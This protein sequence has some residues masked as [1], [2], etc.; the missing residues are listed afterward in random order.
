MG[1]PFISLNAEFLAVTTT[2]NLRMNFI[3][4]AAHDNA[5]SECEQ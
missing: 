5:L 1:W 4:A 3:D 2:T